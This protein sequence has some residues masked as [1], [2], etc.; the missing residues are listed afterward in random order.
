[1]QKN[2]D[3]DNLFVGWP[4]MMLNFRIMIRVHLR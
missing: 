1:M 2:A 3:Q 4:K